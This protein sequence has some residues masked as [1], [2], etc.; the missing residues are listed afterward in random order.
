MDAVVCHSESHSKPFCPYIFTCQESAV[1]FD[2]GF[3]YTFNAEPSLGLLL[4]VLLLPC[5]REVP[6]LWVC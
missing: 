1:W 5:V 2:S 3:C 4:G 6:K